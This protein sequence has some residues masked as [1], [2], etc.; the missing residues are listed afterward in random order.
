MDLKMK[1]PKK[2]E[3]ICGFRSLDFMVQQ[4]Y[5]DSGLWKTNAP[6]TTVYD[7]LKAYK[8]L[9]SATSATETFQNVVTD[10]PAYR[11]LSR[12]NTLKPSFEPSLMYQS[13]VN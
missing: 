6:L 9:Q 3:I 5:Y 2:Q 4:T 8:A 11:M 7:I 13:L 1:P 12:E 10:S